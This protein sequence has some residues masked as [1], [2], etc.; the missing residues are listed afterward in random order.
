MAGAKKGG[1]EVEAEVVDLSGRQIF[2]PLT[3]HQ[4]GATVPKDFTYWM[5]LEIN[6]TSSS[7]A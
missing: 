2:K 6:S 4:L 7:S 3:L 5:W 1:L